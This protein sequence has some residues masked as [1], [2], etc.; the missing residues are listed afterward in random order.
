VETKTAVIKHLISG[1]KGFVFD[2]DGTLLT[3]PVDWAATA[4]RLMEITG[5]TEFS[6]TFETLGQIV[7]ERPVLKD[8][9][10]AAID[11]FE[12]E[13]DPRATLHEGSRESLALLSRGAK[14]AL[15]TMQ[16]SRTRDRLLERFGLARWFQA[17]ESR[18]DSL[19]RAEQ[20]R[21]AV[22]K[23]GVQERQVVF[24]ADRVHDMNSASRAG[25]HFVMIRERGRPASAEGFP[26]MKAFYDFL[27]GRQH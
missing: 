3:L 15:V 12:M 23:L 21:L 1:A 18:E 13:A 8:Q 14:L 20:L 11:T 5:R 24:V 17:F 4:V 2:M 16:G 10:F 26:D 7:R 22:A 6:P 19:D 9:L 27:Q 25:L